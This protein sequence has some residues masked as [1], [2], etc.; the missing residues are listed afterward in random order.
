MRFRC[1]L[2]ATETAPLGG[3][4]NRFSTGRTVSSRIY[5]GIACN[6][7]LSGIACA[8]AIAGA[9]TEEVVEVVAGRRAG[10]NVG[11]K[12]ILCLKRAGCGDGHWRATTGAFGDQTGFVVR[13]A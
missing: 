9:A 11:S 12:G 4:R 6:I 1:E 7:S 13:G 8:A 10:I 2:L 5:W 3:D